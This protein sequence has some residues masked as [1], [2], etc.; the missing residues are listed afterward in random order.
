MNG[1]LFAQNKVTDLEE[2]GTL[3][4]L[5]KNGEKK[6]ILYFPVDA[7]IAIK[8][9]YS[10]ADV[11]A[12]EKGEKVLFIGD[13]ITQG[14]GTFE[15]GQTFVNV[16]N[17]ILNYEILNQGIGGYYFDKNSLMPLEKFTPDKVV[18]AM[19]TNLCYWDDKEKY[20]IGRAHV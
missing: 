13:S 12:V 1:N 11:F 5:L 3:E 16:A 2:E 17:R 14:F 8:N 19:G 18:I 10:D 6:V 15:T 9:F 20:E 7:D 4:Y